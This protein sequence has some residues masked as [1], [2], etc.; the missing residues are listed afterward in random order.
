ML[1]SSIYLHLISK[2]I[3]PW[4]SSIIHHHPKQNLR[5]FRMA[6]ATFP[7]FLELP[8]ELHIPVWKDAIKATFEQW[9]LNSAAFG[10]NYHFTYNSITRSRPDH[11]MSRGKATKPWPLMFQQYYDSVSVLEAYFLRCGGSAWWLDVI[12]DPAEHPICGL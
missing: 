10:V 5:I 4:F 8:R 11:I 7:R 6:T 1:K 2:A 12:W 3:A 9:D